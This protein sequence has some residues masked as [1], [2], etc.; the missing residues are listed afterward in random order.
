MI[1]RV[2]SPDLG[3]MKLY[4]LPRAG[5]VTRNLTNDLHARMS[6]GRSTL[7]KT[8]R[9][10]HVPMEI[11]PIGQHRFPG[12]GGVRTYSASALKVRSRTS[13]SAPIE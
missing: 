8:S 10:A 1:S 4:M 13:P 5:A 6:S 11:R 12:V 9:M 3:S 2:T 7:I